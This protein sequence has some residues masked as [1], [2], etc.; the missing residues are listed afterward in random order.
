MTNKYDQRLMI[1]KVYHSI[2]NIPLTVDKPETNV[3]NTWMI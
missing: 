3:E 1:V 2:A